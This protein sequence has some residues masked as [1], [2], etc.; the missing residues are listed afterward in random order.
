MWIESSSIRSERTPVPV[1][2]VRVCVSH[3][4]CLQ[5]GHLIKNCPDNPNKETA[6][7]A[8]EDPNAADFDEEYDAAFI[9]TNGD[10]KATVLFINTDV[11]IDN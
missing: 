7:V 1:Q 2:P 9:C 11:L 10:E 3:R 8:L 6:L 5:K 4:G